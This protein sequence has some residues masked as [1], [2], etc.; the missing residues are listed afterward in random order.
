[1]QAIS[2]RDCFKVLTKES[3][4][5]PEDVI[6]VQYL[7]K[8]TNCEQLYKRCYEYAISKKALCFYEMPTG[9][10]CNILWNMFLSILFHVNDMQVSPTQECR[11][12]E[13][14]NAI[15]YV[16]ACLTFHAC[17]QILL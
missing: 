10:P 9:N 14:N 1:M 17:I 6:F 8:T 11:F 16:L 2:A 15:L 3:L 4:F 7:L 12:I 5:T 13:W